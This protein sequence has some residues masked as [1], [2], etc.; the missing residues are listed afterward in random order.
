MQEK[1]VGY[2]WQTSPMRVTIDSIEQQNTS[3]RQYAADNQK[4]LIEQFSEVYEI[5]PS[6]FNELKK[7]INLSLEKDAIL[8]IAVLGNLLGYSDF[9]DL[10]LTPNLKFICLDNTAVSPANLPAIVSY[11]QQVKRAHSESIK[12]G[13]SR[14]ISPL[15]NPNA[16]QIINKVNKIKVENAV[17]FSL[18]LQPIIA[19]YE[20]E[21][22]S[23][24][25]IVEKL[26]DDGYTAPEGGQWVLSQ[27]QKVLERIK[28]N[29]LALDLAPK[30]EEYKNNGLNN[31]EIAEKLNEGRIFP[32][33]L[34]KWDE[35]A[36]NSVRK[37]LQI[38]KS[39][40]KLYQLIES[41]EPLLAE[42]EDQN[43]SYQEIAD[44]LNKRGIEFPGE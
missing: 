22:L 23:Q 9:A 24:R 19:Q 12:E 6:D 8:V 36:V 34:D 40:I 7:A 32:H 27:F 3:V 37:R 26:N 41:I 35:K 16:L 28:T 30:L 39:V 42:F 38:I 4:E 29:E 10:L 11:A 33:R 21:G 43:L 25:K 17:L 15:G 14:T 44:E 1:L 5:K 20:S 18:A 13:L 2:S 31:A